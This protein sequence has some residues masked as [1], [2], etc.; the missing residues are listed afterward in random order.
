MGTALLG[1]GGG[2]DHHVGMA[3]KAADELVR[4]RGREVLG[5]LEAHHEVEATIEIYRT[6][7]VGRDEPIG[8]DEELL[9]LDIATVETQHVCGP[10]L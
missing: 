1:D 8:C 6:L 4:R 7:E 2:E 9:A 10:E 5:D 3:D